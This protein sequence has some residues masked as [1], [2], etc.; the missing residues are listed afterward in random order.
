MA[1][2][3]L[4]G[5][6]PRKSDGTA[7]KV[8]A[9]LGALTVLTLL[10]GGVG[11]ALGLHLT[12][13]AEKAVAERAKQEQDS[14]TPSSVKYSG[15]MVLRNLPPIITNLAAPTDTWIRLETSMVFANGALQNPDVTAAEIRQDVVAYARTVSLS[16]L[17]S[18]SAL[19]HL[20][21][22]LNERVALRTGGKVAELIV[23]TVVVQ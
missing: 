2:A 7:R 16:Q 17:Q 20:R 3:A 14:K 9:W 4:P 19:Q 21:E 10:A 22:D 11:A 5:G 23:E 18:P 12:A 13:E 6:K 1:Q 8:L 15:D